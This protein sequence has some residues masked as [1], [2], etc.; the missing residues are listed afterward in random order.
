MVYKLYFIYIVFEV[1]EIINPSKHLKN[2]WNKII[3]YLSF[4]LET[5]PMI[6]GPQKNSSLLRQNNMFWILK[7]FNV[8]FMVTE[9]RMWTKGCTEW[10]CNVPSL[11]LALFSYGICTALGTACYSNTLLLWWLIPNA[12]MWKQ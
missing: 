3:R 8:N 11:S 12:K 9:I 6:L 1:L 2:T 4:A 10:T 5:I 7:L